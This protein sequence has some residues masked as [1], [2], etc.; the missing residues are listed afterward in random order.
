MTE[1]YFKVTES[2]GLFETGP[3]SLTIFRLVRKRGQELGQCD[4]TEHFNGLIDEV[5]DV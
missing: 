3:R 1:K 5:A 2:V 4:R